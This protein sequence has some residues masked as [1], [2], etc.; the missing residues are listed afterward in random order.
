MGIFLQ[1]LPDAV[2]FMVIFED[3]FHEAWIVGVGKDFFGFAGCV[4]DVDDFH[5]FILEVRAC[6]ARSPG[7][8]GLVSML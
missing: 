8:F 2:P 5:S 4:V 3:D 1:K 6:F 7:T